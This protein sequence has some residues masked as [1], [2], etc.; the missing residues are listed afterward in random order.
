MKLA[1]REAI[2]EAALRLAL[3]YGP[4]NV[5]V[6][7]IAAAAGVSPRTYNNYFA[8]REQ[9]ICAAMAAGRAL[10]TGAALR[11]RPADE[12]LDEAI[13]HAMAGEHDT[14]P[15]R[16]VAAMITAT[17]ALRGEYLKTYEALE[18]V[19]ARSIA[20]RTG[21]DAHKDLG[22][23]ILAAAAAG[24][25]RIATQQWLRPEVTAPFTDVLRDALTYVAP[26]ARALDER[27][28]PGQP[29]IP[30]Q[31]PSAGRREITSSPKRPAWDIGH[32]QP[33]FQGLADAGLVRGRVLDVGC[34]T[35]EHALMAAGLGL[36][37]IGVDIDSSAIE[38]AQA[39]ARERGHD[40]RFLV[41]DALALAGLW[42]EF[43]TVLD[44]G[45]FHLFTDEERHVFAENLGAVMP[46]G[47]RYF[48]LCFSD[49]Q[50]GTLGPRRI[51]QSEIRAIFANGWRVDSIEPASLEIT[52]EPRSAHAWLAS[53][54]RTSGS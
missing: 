15:D 32:P 12:P 27:H 4:E 50:P 53:V 11:A 37:V 23:K 29:P 28:G 2:S 20:A 26:L 43:D 47:A 8:G 17:P 3:E 10:R 25:A 35:G 6:D 40:A 36:D 46:A 13:V 41:L 52:I 39:K 31:V 9:A 38:A 5:R 16:R 24:A 42:G 19:L 45:L 30:E 51:A 1:T 18:Q 49:R 34:G 54:T 44:C 22:P 14:E 7:D 48:M 33:A 21:R